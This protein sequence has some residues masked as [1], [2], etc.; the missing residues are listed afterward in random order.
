MAFWSK[1]QPADEPARMEQP[2]AELEPLTP[3]PDPEPESL[4][5][6]P[7]ADL[8]PEPLRRRSEV[9]KLRLTPEELAYLKEQ[10][11][12]ADMSRTDYIMTVAQLMPVIVIDDVPQLMKELR[13]QGANLNQAVR[14][15]HQT[16]SVE[17]PELKAAMQRCAETQAEVARMCD[18]WNA[19][20]RQRTGKGE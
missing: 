11:D 18:R 14:L 16:H 3:A 5:E 2:A 7:A 20:L 8:K 19:K 4:P 15:A 9:L 17:L 10:A 6:P 1:K 12:A 13:R